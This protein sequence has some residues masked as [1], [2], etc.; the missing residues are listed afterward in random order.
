MAN[1]GK[2]FSH[3]EKIQGKYCGLTLVAFAKKSNSGAATV[4]RKEVMNMLAKQLTDSEIAQIAAWL[5]SIKLT[6]EAP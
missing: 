3:F 5:S 4:G 6:V 2:K 1:W